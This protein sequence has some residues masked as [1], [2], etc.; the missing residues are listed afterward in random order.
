MFLAF[1]KNSL[2]PKDEVFFYKVSKDG[3]VEMLKS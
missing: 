3:E 1:N 2:V